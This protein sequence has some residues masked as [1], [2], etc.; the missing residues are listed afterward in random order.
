MNS[1]AYIAI[2]VSS[3]ALMLLAATQW[4]GLTASAWIGS[5]AF[6]VVI[7]STAAVVLR[8]TAEKKRASAGFFGSG[9]VLLA[10][11]YPWCSS[12]IALFEA[13][14]HRMDAEP[15]VAIV[16]GILG[17]ACVFRAWMLWADEKRLQN[18]SSDRMPGTNTP[19]ESGRP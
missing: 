13:P 19:G 16:V 14:Y 2:A 7:V 8:V 4:L 1:R 11:V 5:G 3:V 17:V 10:V 9:I 18:Q 15:P 6:L 12:V